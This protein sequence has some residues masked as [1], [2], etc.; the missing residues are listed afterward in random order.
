MQ[1]FVTEN[2]M[3]NVSFIIESIY[4]KWGKE[5]KTHTQIKMEMATHIYIFGTYM[6]LN[7]YEFKGI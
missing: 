1:P 6:S 3:N 2:R 4:E 7:F 5:L